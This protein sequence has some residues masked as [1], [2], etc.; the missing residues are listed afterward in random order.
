MRIRTKTL[1]VVLPISLVLAACHITLAE[2][3]DFDFETAQTLN[4]TQEQRSETGENL[5]PADV[6]PSATID[7]LDGVTIDIQNLAGSSIVQPRM[8]LQGTYSGLEPGV[9]A[10]HILLQ[11]SNA[12][13]QVFPVELCFPATETGGGWTIPVR[14]GDD[15]SIATPEYFNIFLAFS[16]SKKARMDLNAGADEGFPLFDLPSGVFLVNE[17]TDLVRLAYE[18]VY[19]NRLIY[20]TIY[21]HDGVKSMDI[22][23]ISLTDPDDN[24]YRRL[25]NTAIAEVQPALCPGNQKIAFVQI[26]GYH[27]EEDPN[28]AIWIMDSNGKNM[29]EL[30]DEPEIVYDKPVWSADCRYIAFAAMD[31]NT[32]PQR[33]V[34]TLLDYLNPSAAPIQLT[35]GR[36]PSWMPGKS[37]LELVF[38]NKGALYRMDVDACLEITNQALCEAAHLTGER[39]VGTHPAISP[40]GKWLAFASIPT[41]DE[42]SGDYRQDIYIYD[43]LW[44]G[45]PIPVAANPNLDWRPVW[46]PDSQKLYFESGRTPYFSIFSVSLDG[47]DLQLLTDPNVEDQNPQVVFQDAYFLFPADFSAEWGQ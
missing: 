26:R 31:R 30:L 13:D 25:T 3:D 35:A 29:E 22:V 7:Y 6:S 32:E 20:N 43:L 37:T 27:V 21:L 14:F 36:Y 11:S 34:I 24:D 38:E 5:I 17:V 2:K 28:W 33:W 4:E 16:V 10:I 39:L 19:E 47:S 23:S 46:G 42:T 44:G 18:H 45:D 1:F 40:D 41:L 12:G 9:S 8:N 15:E